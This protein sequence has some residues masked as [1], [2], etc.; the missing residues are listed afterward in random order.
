MLLSRDYLK[1]MKIVRFLLVF[2][3]RNI[4]YVQIINLRQLSFNRYDIHI[5]LLIYVEIIF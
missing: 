1:N 3:T 4:N 2:V 5:V